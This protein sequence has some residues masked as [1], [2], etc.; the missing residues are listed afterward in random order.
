MQWTL[1]PREWKSY[2]VK[3]LL[4]GQLCS[5]EYRPRIEGIPRLSVSYICGASSLVKECCLSNESVNTQSDN[6]ANKYNLY[7]A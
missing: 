5:M 2:C 1:Q 7:S 6:R 4:E 3:D